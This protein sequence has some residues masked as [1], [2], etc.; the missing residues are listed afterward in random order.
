MILSVSAYSPSRPG[1]AAE[2]CCVCVTRRTPLKVAAI[3]QGCG[4]QE[5]HAGREVQRLLQKDEE[6]P[7]VPFNDS[8]L[9]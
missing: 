3:T 8:Q 5:M 7:K 2:W 9:E 1:P 4:R 6:I